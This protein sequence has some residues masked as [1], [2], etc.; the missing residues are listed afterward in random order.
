LPI[1]KPEIKNPKNPKNKNP[2][3]TWLRGNHALQLPVI[4]RSASAIIAGLPME[5][6]CAARPDPTRGHES[7]IRL[8][9]S[10]NRR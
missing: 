8:S 1:Q 3:K 4:L 9:F 5:L 6:G 7:G 2:T 10:G